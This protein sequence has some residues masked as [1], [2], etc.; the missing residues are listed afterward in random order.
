MEIDGDGNMDLFMGN[1]DGYKVF[2]QVDPFLRDCNPFRRAG[3]PDCNVNGEPDPIELLSGPLDQCA[4]EVI[5]FSSQLGIDA[6]SADQALGKP[7]TTFYGD[8]ELAWS[9]A[10]TNGSVEFLTL[11]FDD[12]VFATGVAIRES[13]GNGFVTGV[14][15][16]DTEGAFT[17]VWTGTD[18]SLPGERFDFEVNWPKTEFSTVGVRIHVDTDNDPGREAIDSVKLRGTHVATSVDENEN[19]IPDECECTP[20]SAP[21]LPELSVSTNRFLPF[22]AGN[23]GRVLAV[24]VEFLS[25]PDAYAALNGTIAWVGEP[26]DVSE[27]SSQSDTTLPTFKVAPLSCNPVF[28]DWSEFGPLNVYHRNIAPGGTYRLQLVEVNCPGAEPQYLS[29]PLTVDTAPWGG[30]S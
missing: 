9:P 2:L 18:T 22:Q 10:A 1:C 26:H 5:A 7:D 29:A 21:T 8:S 3:V 12:P 16:L 17:T 23:A 27:V 19:T 4:T 30:P 24:R 13:E 6:H 14:D 25:M 11:G 15:V 28:H 20:L